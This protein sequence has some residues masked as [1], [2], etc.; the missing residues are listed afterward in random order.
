[1]VVGQAR[2]SYKTDIWS[3]GVIYFELLTGKLPFQA[4]KM[5]NLARSMGN[6]F[7]VMQMPYRPCMEALHVITRCLNQNEDERVSIEELSEYPYFFEEGYLPHYLN[8]GSSSDG[9]QTER[10]SSISTATR[11]GLGTARSTSGN[12]RSFKMVL[13]S[14]D[15]SF[16]KRLNETISKASIL[17]PRIGT[18]TTKFGPIPG[19]ST[20]MGG[21]TI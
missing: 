11:G 9:N 6:G 18:E 2:Y 10:S 16:S 5:E 7:Y 20:L 15:S 21:T 14:K 12:R 19:S 8:D 13:T 4:D 3:L 17:S 1:M